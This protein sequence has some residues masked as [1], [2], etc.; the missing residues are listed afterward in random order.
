LIPHRE[1]KATEIDSAG[2]P[3]EGG[4]SV[5]EHN[6]I[7]EFTIISKKEGWTR[8]EEALEFFT[9]ED[10]VRAVKV[11]FRAANSLSEE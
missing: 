6:F 7:V 8:A 11:A 3:G 4:T 9:E 1:G 2:Q 5:D 10:A